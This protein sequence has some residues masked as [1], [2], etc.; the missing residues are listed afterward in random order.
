LVGLIGNEINKPIVVPNKRPVKGIAQIDP[1][2]FV[3]TH[4][5]FF[6]VLKYVVI[7]FFRL[8]FLSLNVE[9]QSIVIPV[10]YKIR[11]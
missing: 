3:V 2:V 1:W 11:V 7:N 9:T 8:N 5:L 4:S 6:I 10:T